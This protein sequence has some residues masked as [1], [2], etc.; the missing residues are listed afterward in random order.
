MSN[1]GNV[2]IVKEVYAAF[3]K[4]DLQG[5]LGLL[6]PDVDWAIPGSAPWSGEGRGHDYVERFFQ[7]FG[8]IAALNAFEPRSFLAD[9]DRV[10]VMGYEEGTVRETGRAWKSHFTHLFTIANG[11]VTS[12]REYADTEAI[13]QAF[14]ARAA[15][16]G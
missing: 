16:R 14:Y 5:L 11:K 1:H 6:G 3:G 8:S 12:H 9:G 2:E 4:G 13:A 7:T 15:A 10:A